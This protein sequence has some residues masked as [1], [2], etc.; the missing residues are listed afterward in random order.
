MPRRLASHHTNSLPLSNRSAKQTCPYQARKKQPKAAPG[1]FSA[2]GGLWR[3]SPVQLAGRDPV[4]QHLGPQETSAVACAVAGVRSPLAA[5]REKTVISLRLAAQLSLT[6]HRYVWIRDHARH[7][8]LRWDEE[9]FGHSRSSKPRI[10][11]PEDLTITDYQCQGLECLGP[12][13]MDFPRNSDSEI[14]S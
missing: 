2:G 1:S 9:T 4:D 8:P 12:Y 7:A 14:L 3:K 6:L 5:C 10:W 11:V 13:Y